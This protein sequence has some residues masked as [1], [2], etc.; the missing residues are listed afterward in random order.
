MKR[1]RQEVFILEGART[2]FG[3]FLGSFKN[4]D[5]NILGSIAAKAAMQ[6]SGVEPREIDHVV[7]GNVIQSSPQAIY[8]ARHVALYSGI[9]QEV[10][11]L[12]VN[13]LCGSGAEAIVQA[14]YLILSGEADLVLAGGTENMTQIPHVIRGARFGTKYGEIVARDYLW[15]SLNDDYCGLQ[16]ALTAEKLAEIYKITRQDADEYAYLT[17]MRY[18]LAKEAGV[19]QEEIVPVEVTEGKKVILVQEDEHPRPDTTLEGLAQLKPVFKKDGIITAGNSSGIVD[20]AAAVVVASEKK[21]KE[22]GLKPLGRVVSWG[23]SAVDPSIMGIGPAPASRKALQ[24]ANLSLNQIDRIEVN[25]AF[26]PQYLA[27]EK[28]LGLDREKTNVNGGATAVGH[29]L[30]ATG[31]RLTYT[32]LKEM[33]R[34]ALTY[35]LASMCI[36]GGQGITLIVENV[37]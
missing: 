8:T 37:R 31:V 35:G 14:C 22:K 17:Q 15:E 16:M 28:E 27:V 20:G 24:K 1:N 30:G 3:K 26:V 33:K 32:V 25:E 18:K 21:V 23:H 5:A 36:G 10:P 29:P 6:K 19:F 11:A 4:T 9:P 13:R 12:T 2:P 7:F 34:K